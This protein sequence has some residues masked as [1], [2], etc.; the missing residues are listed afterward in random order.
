MSLTKNGQ[1]KG[2]YLLIYILYGF[3]MDR[4]VRIPRIKQKKNF[5][6]TYC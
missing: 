1:K 6:D 3:H 2:E 5:A 4:F